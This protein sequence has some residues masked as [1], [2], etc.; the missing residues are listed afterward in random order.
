MSVRVPVGAASRGGV[1]ELGDALRLPAE[2]E[3]GARSRTARLGLLGLLVT[4]A[5]VAVCAAST[6]LL[7]PEVV[8]PIPS[9]LAGPLGGLGPGLSFGVL[10]VVLGAMFVSYVTV[11]HRATSLS[12]RAVLG[13]IALLHLIIL[14]APPLVSTDVF[15]YQAYGRMGGLYG[16]NPYMH[17]PSTIALDPLYGFIGARWVNTPTVYGPL[18]TLLSYVLAPLGIAAATLTYKSIAAAAS[19]ATVALI[20]KSARLRGIDGR[21]AVALFGLNPLV[22][23]YGVGGGHN[24]LLMLAPMLAGLY[25]MLSGRERY[26][27]GSFVLAAGFKLTAGLLLP[28][29]LAAEARPLLRERRRETLI[30]GG[31]MA[32]AIAALSFSVFGVGSLHFALTVVHNQNQGDWHSIAGVITVGLRLK[33]LGHIV[34]LLLGAGFV[35]ATGLLLR[36]VWLGRI[37]WIAAAGWSVFALLLT[38]SMVLPWY[39]AWLMPLAGLSGDRRLTRASIWLTG[40]VLATQLLGDVPHGILLFGP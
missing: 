34:G 13:T 35:A 4:F 33:L 32:A 16:F 14:L 40:I 27:A 19:L 24:D 31:L 23:L 17:G 30:G 21:R 9:W 12:P 15:S 22:V 11:A 2:G 7:L 18:F 39:L 8:R 3:A 28:F 10:A 20:W 6:P 29:A 37:D 36:R 1:I 5:I 26:G 25:L 38:A